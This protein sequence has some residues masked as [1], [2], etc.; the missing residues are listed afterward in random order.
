MITFAIV[1]LVAILIALQHLLN[2]LIRAM[3]ERGEDNAAGIFAAIV[4]FGGL[5]Y[6]CLYY[7]VKWW[8]PLI[9]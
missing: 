3:S 5:S 4:V 9:N 8:G 2:W 6:L 7:I 1:C